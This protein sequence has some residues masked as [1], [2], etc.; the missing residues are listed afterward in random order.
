MVIGMDI[1]QCVHVSWE[2]YR[3]C[4]YI[5]TILTA[6]SCGQVASDTNPSPG[7]PTRETFGGTVTYNCNDG[8][9]L[10]GIATSTCQANATW[11]R[12]PECRG[13]YAHSLLT[14]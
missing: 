5:Y 2:V 10:F 11:S 6:V 14:T 12:P 7:T 3:H 1:L 8:Y 9:A 13:T 4:L